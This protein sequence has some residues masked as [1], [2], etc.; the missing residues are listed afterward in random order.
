MPVVYAASC[1]AGAPCDAPVKNIV[2]TATAAEASP[3]TIRTALGALSAVAANGNTA[4]TATL[5]G[6]ENATAP[7]RDEA[8]LAL[9]AAAVRNPGHV[10]AWLD[11]AGADVR[12][13]A[14]RLLKDGFEDLEEDFGKEQFYAA[15]RAAYWAAGEG[16]ASRTLAA[17]LIQQLEF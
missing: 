11:A 14:I 10:I 3:G 6:L 2:A 7:V 13:R 12:E 8:A 15:A 4:A 16:S 9:A 1:L 5:V 17:S